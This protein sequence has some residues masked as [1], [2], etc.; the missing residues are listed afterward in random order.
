MTDG[1][2]QEML[3]LQRERVEI[4]RLRLEV[5]QKRTHRLMI[6]VSAMAVIVSALQ[7]VVA[8]QQRQVNAAQT[9]ERF[10]P[11][12]L[13]SESKDAALHTMYSFL[14]HDMVTQLAANLRATAVLTEVSMSDS[15][16]QPHAQAALQ[17]IERE[18][19]Q[20]IISMFAPDR[21][22]RVASTQALM[23]GWSDDGQTV[24]ALIG[25]ALAQPENDNGIVNSLVFLKGATMSSLAANADAVDRLLQITEDKGPI[26]RMHASAL[27]RHIQQPDAEYH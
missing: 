9:V 19:D 11:H 2:E 7:V 8:F 12:L 21:D 15:P 20:L 5:E 23:R 25:Q 4:E 27:A 24:A 14:S 22:V 18:R 6:L 17:S 10:I 1:S 13:N 26:T 3:R 16:A